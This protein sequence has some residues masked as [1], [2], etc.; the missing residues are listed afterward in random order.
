MFMFRITGQS[1]SF[2]GVLR[3]SASYWALTEPPHFTGHLPNSIYLLLSPVLEECT[4]KPQLH[5]H[6]KAMRQSRHAWGHRRY[7]Q[8]SK[9]FCSSP[10]ITWLWIAEGL[11]EVAGPTSQTTKCSQWLLGSPV[12]PEVQHISRGYSKNHLTGAWKR[13][14][15]RVHIHSF[16]AWVPGFSAQV[17]GSTSHHLVVPKRVSQQ[18]PKQ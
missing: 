17:P 1:C 6:D 10:K 15:Q 4:V 18:T 3:A 9:S 11:W 16:S 8:S 2:L 14:F 13:K 7:Q 5:G 12:V